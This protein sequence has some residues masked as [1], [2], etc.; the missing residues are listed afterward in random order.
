ME[1]KFILNLWL[2][3][4]GIWSNISESTDKQLRRFVRF[5]QFKNHEKH[6]WRS[7]TFSEIAR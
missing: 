6:P 2:Y 3:Q 5:S 4:H 1:V 7:V